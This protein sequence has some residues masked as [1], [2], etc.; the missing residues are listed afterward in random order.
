M[1]GPAHGRRDRAC[2]Y[3]GRPGLRC[4]GSG[5]IGDGLQGCAVCRSA[6][7]G[8][9]LAGATAARSVA[10]RAQA[11]TFSRS[12]PQTRPRPGEAVSEDCLFLNVWTKATSASEK[13]P[14][15]VWFHGGRF[16]FG[17]GAEP[18]FDGEGLARKGVVVVTMNYRLGVFG[19]LATPEL[20]KDSGHDASGNW[21]L[22]DQIECLRWVRKNIAGFGG[23]PD[24]VTIFGQSAGGGSV[25]L[26]CNSP[27]AKGLY[28]RAICESGARFPRDPDLRRL[29]V[30]WRPLNNAEAAGARYAEAHGAR[31]LQALRALSGTS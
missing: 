4:S 10:R 2:A 31:S 27:L 22:L 12:C 6:G 28:H 21:G 24:R 5:S 25:L 3:G 17:S 13:R 14:V 8:P 19:F 11:E 18:R 7:R 16:I 29:S 23:D 1:S 9:A 30:S 15:M 20:S 26:L